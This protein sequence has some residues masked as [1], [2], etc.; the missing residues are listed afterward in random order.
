MRRASKARCLLSGVGCARRRSAQI[1]AQTMQPGAPMSGKHR[2]AAR[3][4]AYRQATDR[5]MAVG[6]ARRLTAG[7]A[8]FCSLPFSL[9]MFA[10][11][12]NKPKTADFDHFWVSIQAR[13]GDMH[14]GAILLC[15]LLKLHYDAHGCSRKQQLRV[16]VCSRWTAGDPAWEDLAHVLSQPLALPCTCTANGERAPGSAGLR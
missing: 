8:E 9:W 7:I 14:M 11:A 6:S 3:P 1:N 13:R 5:S 4:D 2:G 12:T 16:P 15:L 10:N